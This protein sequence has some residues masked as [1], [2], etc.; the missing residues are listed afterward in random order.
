MLQGVRVIDFSQ[1]LPGPF[2]TLRLADLGAEVIKVEPPQGDPSRFMAQKTLYAAN[3]RGKKSVVIDLKEEKGQEQALNLLKKADVVVE[4]FRPGVMD[5]L[6]LGF[7][8]VKKV[9]E[10]IVYLSLTGFGQHSFYSNQGSHDINYLAMSGMLSQLKDEHGTPILPTNTVADLIGGI[11][12]SEAILA[13]LFL[14][15][16]TGQGKYIDLAMTDAVFSMMGN[17]VMLNQFANLSDG[18]PV[19]NGDYANYRIYETKDSR[20]MSLGALEYKFWQNFCQAVNRQDWLKNFPNQLKNKDV[21]ENVKQLFMTKTFNEWIEL[22]EMHDCCLF[23]VLEIDEV[24]NSQYID[25]RDLIHCENGLPFVQPHNGYVHKSY[26]TAKLGEHT[27]DILS[28][29]DPT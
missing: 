17:H 26:Q 9:N 4:S 12:A 10:Q 16:R 27:N 15:E 18:I 20:Y 13:A 7:E 22:G 5:R 23:P 14:K 21:T 28:T 8:D 29:K 24:M 11:T 3:N 2:A 25:E 19:L 1:Y 6:G